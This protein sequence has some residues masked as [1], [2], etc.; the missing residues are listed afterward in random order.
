MKI[1]PAN[2]TQK[3]NNIY[4]R[5]FV[6]L[7]QAYKMAGYAT[8]EGIYKAAR[9]GKIRRF[10]ISKG[11]EGETTIYLKSEIMALKKWRQQLE[12]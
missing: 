7:N 2:V 6:S 11:K 8:R 1:F 4:M 10:V 5:D 9:A 12:R 3:G